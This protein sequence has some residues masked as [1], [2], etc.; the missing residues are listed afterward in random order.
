MPEIK[1]LDENKGLILKAYEFESERNKQYQIRKKMQV[2]KDLCIP[3]AEGYESVLN[4]AKTPV[5][6]ERIH[7][8][9]LDKHL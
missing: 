2:L 6:L 3:N 8:S 4:A 5:E 7:R 1:E 9:I